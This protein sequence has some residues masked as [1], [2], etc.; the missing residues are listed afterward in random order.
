MVS[1]LVLKLFGALLLSTIIQKEFC[2]C[3]VD[4]TLKSD[5]SCFFHNKKCDACGKSLG[6]SHNQV[7]YFKTFTEEPSCKSFNSVMGPE[8]LNLSLKLKTGNMTSYEYTWNMA[9]E[10]VK[11]CMMSNLEISLMGLEAKVCAIDEEKMLSQECFDRLPVSVTCYK[12]LRVAIHIPPS[13]KCE[14]CLLQMESKFSGKSCFP[15]TLIQKQNQEA[16]PSASVLSTIEETSVTIELEE[17]TV[18]SISST[19]TKIATNTGTSSTYQSSKI[20]DSSTSTFLSRVAPQKVAGIIIPFDSTTVTKMLPVKFSPPVVSQSLMLNT[21]LEGSNSTIDISSADQEASP[22]TSVL[23]TVE[24][25]SIIKNEPEE[26]STYTSFSSTQA[27]TAKITG[28]SN[29]ESSPST[30]VFLAVEEISPITVEPKGTSPASLRSISS[31]QAK[32]ATTTVTSSTYQSSIFL[33]SLASTIDSAA[34]DIP[35]RMSGITSPSKSISTEIQQ[36]KFSPTVRVLNR[37]LMLNALFKGSNSTK[38]NLTAV[39]EN[40]LII[41][42]ERTSTPKTISSTRAKTASITTS[43]I[44]QS[45]RIIDSSVST[46]NF[47]A[48]KSL[49]DNE[50]ITTPSNFITVSEIS[51]AE[52]SSTVVNR[53]LELNAIFESFNSTKHLS[54]AGDVLPKQKVASMSQTSLPPCSSLNTTNMT[55]VS[56]KCESKEQVLKKNRDKSS[57]STVNSSRWIITFFIISIQMI[58]FLD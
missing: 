26:T 7:N 53:S 16:L 31:P 29:Q 28:T 48:E 24:E 46:F 37:S 18:P 55:E 11:D 21:I 42:P 17:A 20:I 25:N 6:Q 8:G 10:S 4:C 35:Q 39:Q 44:Y 9:V 27:K 38:R 12:E 23:S 1:F 34:E 50:G 3:K 58:N 49:E 19:K 47:P 30:T 14:K 54:S 43:S 2:Y 52:I 13:I 36:P 57:A 40:T 51:T 41:E 33:D 45:S 32:I 5:Q 15:L 22:S 56:L